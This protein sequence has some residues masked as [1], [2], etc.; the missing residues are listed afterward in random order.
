MNQKVKSMTSWMKEKDV[1]VSFITSTDNVFYLSNFYSD[2]HERLLAL[3]LFQEEEPILVCPGMEKEDAKNSG[4][5]KDI[6]GYSDIENPWELIKKHPKKNIKS[7]TK[8]AIEKEHMNVERF[9][10][11]SS[12]LGMYP[13]FPQKK[14][15]AITDD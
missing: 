7:V 9:E 14:T 11:I 3:V 2:P 12:I 5:D 4:W 6:I 13:L 15:Y 1:D 10:A 8:V